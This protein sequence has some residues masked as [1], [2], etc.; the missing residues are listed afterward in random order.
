MNNEVQRGGVGD[1]YIAR[2]E[3]ECRGRRRD[4]NVPPVDVDLPSK[5]NAILV[6]QS[7]V[8]S[9]EQMKED[10]KDALG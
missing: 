10:I 3:E 2:K 1:Y 8:G 6:T 7:E 9:E 5:C 4:Q